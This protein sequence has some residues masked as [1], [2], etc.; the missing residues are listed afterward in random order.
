MIFNRLKE[1][2]QKA[3]LVGNQIEMSPLRALV[4]V[5]ICRFRYG[6]VLDDYLCFDF[7]KLNHRGRNSFLTEKRLKNKI[8]PRLSKTDK[9][10]YFE[11]K[12]DF[13]HLF[14]DYIKRGWISS[15]TSSESK[16]LEFLN[17]RDIVFA[18]EVI[19]SQG[20]GVRKI[21]TSDK[22]AINEI[23]ESI[24]KGVHYVFEDAIMQHSYMA[25]FN[26]SSVNTIRMETYID[27]NGVPHFFNS[28]IIIGGKGSIVSNTHTGGV[29]C[30]IDLETGVID[31]SG[32]NPEGKRFLKHPQNDVVLPGKIVPKW[33]E[34]KEYTLKLALVC[35]DIRFVGWDIAIT[36]NGPEVIEGNTFP[37]ACTQACDMV[38]RWPLLKSLI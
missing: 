12:S 10:H 36:D 26:S 19:G 11:D 6:A 24:K 29:M 25:V 20:L 15:K 27:D 7:Q 33:E 4:D 3:T 35:K 32:R 2:K 34:V 14:K 28:I 21:N 17:Q 30:H 38:G 16:I 8:L 9:R 13:N 5:A 22:S 23:F 18:K 1:I 37:G 31:S